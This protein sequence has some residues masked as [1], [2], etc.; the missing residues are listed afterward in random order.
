[1]AFVF[2]DDIIYFQDHQ[3]HLWLAILASDDIRTLQ[4]ERKRKLCLSIRFVSILWII[5]S[6]SSERP[7]SSFGLKCQK[8]LLNLLKIGSNALGESLFWLVTTLVYPRITFLSKAM[9]RTLTGSTATLR[10]AFLS[11]EK[12]R[13]PPA[14]P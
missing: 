3:I 8:R 4:G 7:Q 6:I 5:S 10:Q 1:M 13:P 12:R 2:L 14:V 9:G 11:A